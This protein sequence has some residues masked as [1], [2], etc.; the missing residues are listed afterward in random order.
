MNVSAAISVAEARARILA[1]VSPDRPTELVPLA[2]AYGRTLAEDLAATRTQPS[3]AVSAMDGYAVRAVDLAVLPTKLRQIGESAAGHGFSG[4]LG[5]GETV[6]IFT[7]APL[8]D[9]ADAILMQE[10]AKAEDGVIEP[11][12]NVGAGRFIRA[13]GLDF[14]AGETLLRRGTRLGPS[15]MALAAAMNHAEIKVARRPRVGILATGDE[16]VAPGGAIGPDQ[17]V[18]SN[19]FAVAALVEAAGGEP[20][21]LGIAADA[22]AALEAKIQAA[23]D[24]GADVLVT[25]GGASVGDHDLVRP[26]LAKEGMEFGFWRIAM[27]PGKPLIHGRLG[28][29]AILGLPGNPVSTIVAGL[30]FLSPLVR[31]LSGDPTAADD[32][33]E[34]AALGEAI[35]ENDGRE[36]YLRAALSASP[37]GLP[38]ATPFKAQDSSLLGVLA[39]A[40]CLLIRAPH[41]P[42]AEAGERCRIIRLP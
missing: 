19:S 38:T 11:L 35:G 39:R 17:I 3:K 9:G 41:A 2:R 7:G 26:A 12:R 1:G 6:R 30:L 40:Q 37:D 22:L 4:R 16:L 24:A 5:A 10:D 42:A 15:E 33:S 13:K 27:R 34:P 36:D 14:T 29:M 23:R 31:A 18:A 21:D 28:G 25:L 32:P 8:P 20:I